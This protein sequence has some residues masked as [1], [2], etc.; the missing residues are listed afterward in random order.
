MRPARLDVS[1]AEVEDLRRRLLRT[2]WPRPW[3]PDEGR[4]MPDDGH[5]LRRLAARWATGHDWPAQQ[6]AINALPSYTAEV[7]GTDVH[8][9]LYPGEFPD[10]LPLVV[11]H[12]WP[13]SFLEMPRL[14][15]RLANPSRHGGDPR[16]AFTV[17]VPSLPGF[18]LSP[19][20]PELPAATGT[21]ELWHALMHDEL[22]FERYGAHGGDLGAGVTSLLA[23][24]HPGSVVGAHLLAVADPPDADP[25]TLTPEERAYQASE[26][27]WFA[28]DGGY[29]H[30]QMTRPLTLS[31]GLADSPVGLLAWIV[32]KHREWSDCDGD[33]SRCFP[34]D[35]L[36]TQASLY[37]FTET[38]S[39]SFRP[40]YEYARVWTARVRRVDVPTAVAVFP[41]D[42][43]LPPRT[44]AERTYNVTRYTTMPRGGHFAA[45]EQPG[46]LSRDLVEFFRSLRQR[47]GP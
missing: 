17:V 36:L 18:G 33:V 32:E 5:L 40:Y 4:R 30:E 10:A 23:Q 27:R 20:R 25:D 2:R 41:R 6:S 39:T 43:S 31:H 16:D 13:S 9:L 34:D 42:L 35:Y 19:Q 12:G 45:Y 26:S 21:H 11:T 14:A 47:G 38:I 24:E 29:E 37:W 3:P 46:L 1:P 28:E 15:E 7:A 44:W 22:G 8:F